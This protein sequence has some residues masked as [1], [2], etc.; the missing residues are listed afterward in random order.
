MFN[1]YLNSNIHINYILYMNIPE[2]PLSLVQHRIDQ[3]FN[4]A[5]NIMYLKKKYFNFQNF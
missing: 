2:K 4:I 5:R 3:F 1:T